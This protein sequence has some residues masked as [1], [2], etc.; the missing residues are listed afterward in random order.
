MNGIESGAQV[1]II[2]GVK[3]NN[4]DLSIVNKKVNVIVPT[5]T[6]DITND[7]GFVSVEV[8]GKKLIIS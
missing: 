4:V 1:N 2:D 8:I 6:S 3:V 5:K 7:S